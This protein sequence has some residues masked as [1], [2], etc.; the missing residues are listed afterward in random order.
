MSH[1]EKVMAKVILQRIQCRTDETLSEAQAGFR[2]KRST[3]D[4][5]FTLRLLAEKYVDFGKFL[6]VCYVDFQK[7]FD[8]VWRTGFWR[9]ARFL[10]YDE[11]LVRLLEGRMSAVRVDGGLIEWFVT[12]IGVMHGC[13]LSP[14]LFN[15]LLQVVMA[16]ALDNWESGVKVT[17]TRLSNLRFADDISLLAN[18][19]AVN[20]NS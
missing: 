12:V 8:S 5:L 15:I 20:F 2:V 13:I 3:I 10:G 16:L 19:E 17:G 11:K 4:Q 7:A 1:C 14:L 9:V 18:S 6:N